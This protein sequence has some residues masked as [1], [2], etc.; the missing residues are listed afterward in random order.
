MKNQSILEIRK[1]VMNTFLTITEIT[2]LGNVY[3]KS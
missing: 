1:S 2:I 3:V